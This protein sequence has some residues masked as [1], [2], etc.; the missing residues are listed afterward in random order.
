MI[1]DPVGASEFFLGFVCNYLSLLHNCEDLFLF[2]TFV[3][4]FRVFQMSTV[5][6]V[7]GQQL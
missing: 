2:Y 5:P 7:F 6:R 4:Y 1:H 3:S